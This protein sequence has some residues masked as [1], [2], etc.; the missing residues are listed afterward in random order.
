MLEQMVIG[1]VTNCN[2]I[3][4]NSTLWAIAFFFKSRLPHIQYSTQIFAA[5]RQIVCLEVLM[6]T[7]GTFA[8]IPRLGFSS[9]WLWNSRGRCCWCR[10][11]KSK[12]LNFSFV[13]STM[14]LHDAN[15][16]RI[17]QGIYYSD[18]SFCE[19]LG[20]KKGHQNDTCYNEIAVSVQGL[21]LF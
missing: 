20:V 14:D 2:K 3:K 8:D 13:Q 18:T 19:L 11:M 6:G 5:H 16:L 10:T 1:V 9:S 17:S 12:N 4:P 7:L 21:T 15:S